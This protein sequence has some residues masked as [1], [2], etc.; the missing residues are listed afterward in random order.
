[1][2]PQ[3]PSLAPVALG[4]LM[5]SLTALAMLSLPRSIAAAPAAPW[6]S[7]SV[8]VNVP[9]AYFAMQP[10]LA[11]GSNDDV[12]V[13]YSGGSGG[14]MLPQ[15]IFFSR[16]TDGGRTWTTSA[17]VNNDAGGASQ[18]RPSLILDAAENIFILWT[19]TRGGTSDIYFSKSTDGGLSFSANVRVNDVTTNSQVNGD[20]AVDAMGL[21][22]A[23][24]EDN[25]DS[26]TTGPDIY[27]A[28]STDG[29]LSFNPSARVNNDATPV[30]Q[31]RPVIAVA[32]D[33]SVYVAWD[34]PRNGG[35]GRDIYFSKSTDLG[36]TWAPNIF[37][38]DDSGGTG[39]DSP[40]IAVDEAGTVYIAWSDGR[41]A[42]TAPDIFSTRSTNGGSTFTANVK[43]NDDLA[44]AF[45]YFPSLSANA[46]TVQVMWSDSRTIGSTGVDVFT[47]SSPDGVTWGENIRAN[48]DTIFGNDQIYPSVAVGEAGDVFAA[49]TDE[50]FSGQDVFAAVLDVHAPNAAAPA[51]MSVSQGVMVSFDCTGS[52]DNLGIAGYEWDFGDG[53]SA[54]GGTANHVYST[55]DAYTATCTVQDRSGNTDVTIIAVT[56]LDTEDPV[57]RGGGDR[58]V[59]EG[60][61]VFFDAGASTDNVGVVSY[62]WDFGDGTTST[63]AAG[64]H[65]YAR[66]GTFA[67]SLSVRDEAGN[68]DTA[69]MTVVVRAV[70]PKPSE[71]LAAIQGLWAVVVALTI[72]LAVVGFIAFQTWRRG[73]PPGTPLIGN[74][75]PPRESGP[76]YPPPPPPPPMPPTG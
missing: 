72:A 57:A 11:V 56:V 20:I 24:W 64:S 45:Q 9:L 14:F 26:A 25:R 5:A 71:L 12:Y 42:G 61:S 35:R 38:N 10:S 75:A 49:W 19:D 28:N 1:M 69:T 65:D 30:E 63:E 23:V 47:T 58:A 6:F 43:V 66:P 39:Q 4:L 52:S 51:S 74:R 34:D 70:S 59:S 54:V 7:P 18:S 22:H 62:E 33:R 46:G 48:D 68:E 32:S 16:S 13:A 3:R 55:P 36:A 17:R 27:Y 37:V 15:D 40:T 53:A 31:A 8:G 67:V 60:Q 73:R 29:G 44:A 2:R 76:A 50:R 41:A 21:I